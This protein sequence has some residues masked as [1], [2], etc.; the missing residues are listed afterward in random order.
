[1]W[2]QGGFQDIK[3]D[4][5]TNHIELRSPSFGAIGFAANRFCNLP[6]KAWEI[7]PLGLNKTRIIIHGAQV[8]AEL[9]VE[10]IT[11]LTPSELGGGAQFLRC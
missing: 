11:K 1:M 5:Q 3:F 6:F 9:T 4:I 8:S 7:K 10:V 2:C